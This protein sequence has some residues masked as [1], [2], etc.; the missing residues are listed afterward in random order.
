MD[1]DLVGLVANRREPWGAK[2]LWCWIFLS[3]FWG[4]VDNYFLF[5]ASFALGV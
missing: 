3:L 5:N 4:G 2:M 1:L